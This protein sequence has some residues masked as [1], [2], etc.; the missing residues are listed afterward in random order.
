MMTLN[1]LFGHWSMKLRKHDYPTIPL[2]MKSF[3]D[4][5]S[6][7]VIPH[8]IK[9]V[10]DFKDF[11]DSCICKKRTSWKDILQ[12]NCLYSPGTEMVGLSCSTSITAQMQSGCQKKVEEF[13]FGKRTMMASQILVTGEPNALLPQQMQNHPEIVKGIEGFINFWELLSSEDNTREY[14]RSH[15]HLIHY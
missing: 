3:M 6:L 12:R 15:E 14:W 13:G 10:L 5:E 9:E 7:P 1:F 2:L 8:L 11:I 4:V